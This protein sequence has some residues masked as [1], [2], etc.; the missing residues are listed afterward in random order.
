VK[1][2]TELHGGAVRAVS[3]GI[4]HGATFTLRL[5]RLPGLHVVEAAESAARPRPT[6]L[7]GL[8]VL[9]VDDNRD[10]LDVLA[11]SLA[12]SGA[13]VRSASSGEEALREW[14]RAPADMLICDLA[15]P[16]MDGFAVLRGIRQR[17]RAMGRFT[18]AIAVTAHASPDYQ[19]RTREAG[20]DAHISKPFDGDELVR[21][22]TAVRSRIQMS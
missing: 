8:Q 21:T 10:A 13:D 5:P 7:R 1:E 18:P 2:L 4:G 16:Q 20:F 19:S 12:S 14:D 11:A 22:V 9:A 6:L 15:M 3:A 17:D